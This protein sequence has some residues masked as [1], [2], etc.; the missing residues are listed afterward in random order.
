MKLVVI[1][2]VIRHKKG[3]TWKGVWSWDE[4]DNHRLIL[5]PIEFLFCRYLRSSYSGGYIKLM[6]MYGGSN[7]LTLFTKE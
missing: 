3:R 2:D 7:Y 5:N 1:F 6:S 4:W